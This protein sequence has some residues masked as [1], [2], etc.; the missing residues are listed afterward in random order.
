MLLQHN[1][2][3]NKSSYSESPAMQSLL[4]QIIRFSDNPLLLFIMIFALAVANLFFPPIPLE[5]LTLMAG[6]L[7]GTGRA[8]LWVIIGAT[9]SGMFCGSLILY[10]LS[11]RYHNTVI[12]GT[13]LRKFFTKNSYFRAVGW[14]K[15]YGLWTVFLGKLVPGMSFYTIVCCGIFKLPTPKA[16]AAFFS[17]NLIF[18]TVLAILGRTLGHHWRRIIPWLKSSGRLSYLVVGL[19]I[20]ILLY[21]YLKHKRQLKN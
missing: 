21:L 13:P 8:S 20:I 9:T 7:S 12:S 16:L 17:S 18:F 1:N 6:Y 10:Y 11:R 14:F 2:I 15:K 4:D 5:T 19:V 3:R